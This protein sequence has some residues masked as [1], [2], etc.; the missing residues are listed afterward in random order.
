ME[1]ERSKISLWKISLIMHHS[2]FK[3]WKLFQCCSRR[4]F[5]AHQHFELAAIERSL[6][7]S[8]LSK[9]GY[10]FFQNFLLILKLFIDLKNW[11]P[12]SEMWVLIFRERITFVGLVC[13]NS[14]PS[15]T[16]LWWLP[17]TF[18]LTISMPYCFAGLF[19]LTAYPNLFSFVPLR[20]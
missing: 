5:M 12:H 15:S 4:L 19:A 7:R 9:P 13:F 10:L 17:I 3:L 16:M 6:C 1:G 2:F 18:N 14:A 20:L 8:K 11:R